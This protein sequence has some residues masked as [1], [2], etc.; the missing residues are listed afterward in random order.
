[1]P[2]NGSRLPPDDHVLRYIRK[3]HVDREANKI[4]GAGFLRRPGEDAPSFNWLECFSAPIENQ[5][6]E[7]RRCKRV[8]YEKR[9][10]L[11][12]LNVARTERHIAEKSTLQSDVQFIHDFLD[13]ENGML[14]DLSHSIGRGVPEVGGGPEVEMIGDL[15]LDCVLEIFD[16]PTD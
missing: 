13:A 15:F 11:V 1:V 14:A 6:S 10:K 2:E 5:L 16:A 9:G 4:N 7:I 12:R 3:K 8:Q